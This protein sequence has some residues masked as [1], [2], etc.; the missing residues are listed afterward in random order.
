MSDSKSNHRVP[1]RAQTVGMWLFLA[2]LAMLFGATMA[3]YFI[4]RARQGAVASLQLPRT[5]WISTALML[6]GSTTIHFA[7]TAVRRER[8]QELRRHLIM[9]CIF[10]ALFVIVQ[11]PAMMQLLEQHR[12]LAA[13]QRV[14]LYGMVFFL[15]LVHAL[16]VLGGLVGL[17]VTTANALRGRYDH[18][19]YTGVKSVA[20]YWHF[21]DLVWIIMYLGI[22]LTG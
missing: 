11:T 18:E 15:I 22:F 13:T 5:L 3:G 14:F 20:M 10:A 9:T 19:N 21:L 16:H 8:Q 1:A 17:G 7:L 4:V 12:E 2:A 6:A